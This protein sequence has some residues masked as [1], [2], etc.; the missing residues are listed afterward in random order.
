MRAPLTGRFLG[1]EPS[2]SAIKLFDSED[3]EG[4]FRM[5]LDI[6]RNAQCGSSVS[7]AVSYATPRLLGVAKLFLGDRRSSTS[8][9]WHVLNRTEEGPPAA[10]AFCVSRGWE[11]QATGHAH[12]SEL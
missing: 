3:L 9:W 4:K 7:D 10:E 6:E 11:I 2:I 12:R 8:L 1:F 5:C